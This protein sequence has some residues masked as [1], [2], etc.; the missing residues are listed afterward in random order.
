[1]SFPKP[2]ILGNLVIN[3]GIDWHAADW[4]STFRDW[5]GLPRAQAIMTERYGAWPLVSGVRRPPVRR[6][7]ETHFLHALDADYKLARKAYLQ[8]LDY[9]E[10]VPYR[11][12]CTDVIPPGCSGE[13]SLIAFGPW[14]VQTD[15]LGN[16]T[17]RDLI[18]PEDVEAILTGAVHFTEGSDGVCRAIVI[19]DDEVNEILNPSF[20]INVTDGWTNVGFA[21]FARVLTQHKFGQAALHCIAD[22]AADNAIS[23]TVAN[24]DATEIWTG[25]CWVKLISGDFKLV[26][27]ENAGGWSDLDSVAADT[28]T[29]NEWQKVSVTV[30]LSGGVTDARI[31][32]MPVAGATSEFYVDGINLVE[33]SFVSTHVDGSLGPGYEWDTPTPHNDTSTRTQ[34]QINLDAHAS[35]LSGKDEL[36]FRVVVIPQ[37]DYDDAAWPHASANDIS[38]ARGVDANNRIAI[39]FVNT[40]NRFEVYINGAYRL[41]PT[42]QAFSAGDRIE[43]VV[44][45]DFT[46]DEYKLYYDGVLVD[47]DTTALTAPVLT[48][49]TIGS[50][51]VGNY[52][53]GWAIEQYQVFKKVFTLAEIGVLNAKHLRARWLEALCDQTDPLSFGGKETTL[54]FVATMNIDDD[55]RFRSRDGDV[56]ATQLTD[57]S[58]TLYLDVDSEDLCRPA[59]YITPETAKTE[60]FL[61]KAWFPIVWPVDLAGNNYPIGV[62]GWDTA[63][64]IAAG[65]MLATGN[66]LRVYSDGVEINRWLDGINTAL[67]NVWFN[68]DFV[69]SGNSPLETAILIGDT[70][71]YIDAQNSITA[72]PTVGILLIDSEAFLYEGID[73]TNKRFLNVSRAAR[74]TAAAGHAVAATIHWIQHDVWVYYDDAT[75]AA[76]TVDDTYKPMFELDTSTNAA[77]DFDYFGK[78]GE[79]ERPGTWSLAHTTYGAQ[80][81]YTGHHDTGDTDPWEE[82]G[83]YAYFYFGAG[84]ARWS[85]YSPCGFSN[86]N[87]TDGEEYNGPPGPSQVYLQSSP[88]SIT[89]TNEYTIPV[90]GAAAWNAWT[91]SEAVP[92]GTK[93]VAMYGVSGASSWRYS[94]IDDVIVTM[95]NAPSATLG[96]EQDNYALDLTITNETT[97]QQLRLTTQLTLAHTVEIDTDAKSVRNLSDPESLYGD[98]TQV[99]GIRKEWLKLL[100][101]ENELTI[102]DDTATQLAFFLVFDRRYY[103]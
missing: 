7:L 3:D 6:S 45:L 71:T 77:W 14:D 94:E 74:G 79:A 27:E 43:L 62:I 15:G 34:T 26:I 53:G 31:K 29:L 19:E 36:T 61:H 11:I 33:A 49:W 89:W 30:T 47:T 82:M 16:W 87:V 63:T 51:I 48:D 66:D 83:I 88:D 68:L 96:A 52:N 35:L 4:A 84:G 22:A 37:Y 39:S 100:D 9:E 8:A 20:E 75:L 23:N 17:I 80:H 85:L 73:Y 40:A 42:A 21:T 103:E 65:D 69:P 99:G 102:E 46:N 98:M 55:V 101:G 13:K 10:E 64:I 78:D 2:W 76:P 60:G 32:I 54:G 38:D 67:T 28:G 70:V 24:A 18:D 41:Q 93:Y 50:D 72:F 95:E 56:W 81:W 58:V 86:I 97:G 44:T 5:Q 90:G 91:R 1:M 25:S 12:L 59:M 57:D 92:S